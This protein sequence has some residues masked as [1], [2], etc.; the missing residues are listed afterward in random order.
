MGT[1]EKAQ[2]KAAGLR[3]SRLDLAALGKNTAKVILALAAV[4]ALMPLAVVAPN[5]PSALAELGILFTKTPPRRRRKAIRRLQ[6]QRLIEI[7]EQ[8]DGTTAITL[9]ERGKRR[10][11]LFNLEYLQLERPAQWDGKWRIIAFDIPEKFHAGRRALREKM[12]ELG[13]YPLQ[14]SVFVFPYSCRDEVDFIAD[15]F[16]VGRYLN[17]IEATHID[18]TKHLREHFR[19]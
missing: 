4:G 3:L 1:Q 6:K 19:I 8:P 7:T 15:F 11:L 10:V 14:K 9:T 5:L 16:G 12:R 17:Y 2:N 18:D 13:F